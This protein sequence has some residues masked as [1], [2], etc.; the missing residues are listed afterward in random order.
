MTNEKIDEYINKN[1]AWNSV[2]MFYAFCEAKGIDD[3][4]CDLTD[5]EYSAM[6]NEF[7]EKVTYQVVSDLFRKIN[8]DIDVRIKD[9]MKEVI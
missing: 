5:E 6:E 8:I 1:L 7:Q 3:P 9:A 2:E 4:E